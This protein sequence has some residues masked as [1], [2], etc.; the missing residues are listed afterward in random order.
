LS[1][2]Y[3]Q[4]IRDYEETLHEKNVTLE[5]LASTDGLTGI[6]NKRIFDEVSK[7]YFDSAQRDGIGLSLLMLDLDNFKIIN[8]TYG[9][10]VGDLI[11]VQ[12]ADIIKPLL[13]K[14]DV[15]A[16]IGGEEFS[17]LLFRTEVEGAEILANKIHEAVKNISVQCEKQEITVT[18]SIGITQNKKTDVSF[19]EIVLRADNA[20]YEA[21]DKGRDQTCVAL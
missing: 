10:Q 3:T 6:M 19:E 21:K 5:T 9:H 11:L 1:Y 15:F 12:F 2:V 8:D 17:V 20:L 4:K 18:T 14:S 13:R 16:R 7:N